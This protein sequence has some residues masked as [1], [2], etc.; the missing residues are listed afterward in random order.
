MD[1]GRESISS[2]CRYDSLEKIKES[3][4]EA[5]INKRVQEDLYSDISSIPIDKQ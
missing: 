2:Y 1:L 5:G 3:L 4:H